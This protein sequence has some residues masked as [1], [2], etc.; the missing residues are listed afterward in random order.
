MQ[1]AFHGKMKKGHVNGSLEQAHKTY[2][3]F[4]L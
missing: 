4:Q 1:T 3:T 2:L